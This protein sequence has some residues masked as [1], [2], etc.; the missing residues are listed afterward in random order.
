[1]T[2]L[3]A[4]DSY[5]RRM[6]ERGDVA[7]AGWSQEPVGFVLTLAADGTL[8]EVQ[9]RLDGKGKPRPAL[10]PKWFGR[11]GTGS[12]PF[13]LWDNPAYALGVGDAEKK[14]PAKTAQDH[15][16]FRALHERELAGETDEGLV[17]L[18]RFLATWTPARFAAAPFEARMLPWNLA[19][20]LGDEPR[21]IHERPAARRHVARL[22]GVEEQDGGAVVP[23]LVTGT[24]SAPVRL[25]PKIKGVD[26]T[27][28]AEV[29]LVSFNE[30]AF[31]SHGQEQGLNAPVSRAAAQRYGAALNRLLDRGRNSNR[32]RIA[33]TTVA[34]WA[35]AS[36]AEAREA[37]SFVAA[38]FGGGG[39]EEKPDEEQ[40][41]ERLRDALVAVRDGRAE[42]KVP[43]LSP[44]VRFH[45]LGLSPN[46]ARLSV[47]FWLSDS[48][49]RFA[50]RLV[51]HQE[52]LSILPAPWRGRAPS[53]LR[54]LVKTTAPGEKFENIP[55]AL[56]GEVM[57]AV[58]EGTPYP[59]TLLAAAVTR[60][61][62]GDDAG[63]GWHAAAIRAGLAREARFFQGKEAPPVELDKDSDDPAYNLG[64]FFAVAEI[65]QRMALGRGVKATI[66]DRYYGAFSATPA[67]V[68]PLVQRGMQNHLAKL[69]K[70]GKGGWVEREVEQIVGR[71]PPE[72]PPRFLPLD[73]Q[74]RLAIGYYH[75]RATKIEGKPAAERAEE[76]AVEGEDGNE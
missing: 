74:G 59:R 41:A 60:L 8:L 44:G 4:L 21:L 19:F 38:C 62:A 40:E 1:M 50:E 27:A 7:E 28:S 58:L 15:A 10:V 42:A 32:L 20:R 55:P 31:A 67:S 37:E 54:L 11:S 24:L 23:C 9:T 2:V 57:R 68:F 36:E 30:E 73:G 6:A 72:G 12:T 49:A 52:D 16:A 14:K 39:D 3:A 66:R 35:D 18:L 46:A 17:A 51:R 75:Q 47:R 34:F 22:A 53:V 45:V 64:R 29:P 70:E 56:A 43:E 33:D 13:F 69:R 26:G 76:E 48:F 61:R 71:L 63:T 5:Y 65:A 25:H